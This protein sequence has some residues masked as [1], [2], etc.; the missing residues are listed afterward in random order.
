MP[1]HIDVARLVQQGLAAGILVVWECE[2][3]L[4]DRAVRASSLNAFLG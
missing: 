1:G 2:T 4:R 3:L